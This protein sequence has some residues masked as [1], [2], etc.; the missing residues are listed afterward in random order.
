VILT[1][2][3]DSARHVA[4]SIHKHASTMRNS[5][6]PG[7]SKHKHKEV[8]R[9]TAGKELILDVTRYQAGHLLLHASTQT[10]LDMSCGQSQTEAVH[11]QSRYTVCMNP[12]TTCMQQPRAHA[13]YSGFYAGPSTPKPRCR[14]PRLAAVALLPSC[15]GD[16]LHHHG[17]S[18]SVW[19]PTTACARPAAA[20]PA[21]AAALPCA[22]VALLH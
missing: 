21:V 7:H 8:A 19:H 17:A 11:H 16:R 4:A 15:H 3:R 10:L 18:A 5:K 12:R 9:N 22:A 1:L 14:A 2:R 6:W 20:A 13:H